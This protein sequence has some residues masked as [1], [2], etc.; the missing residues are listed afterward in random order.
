MIRSK[1]KRQVDS[2]IDGM[3]ARRAEVTE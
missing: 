2:W 3:R 1:I